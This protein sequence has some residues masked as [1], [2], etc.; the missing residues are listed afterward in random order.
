MKI[1]EQPILVHEDA[2]NDLDY[3]PSGV[4]KPTHEEISVLAHHFY[5]QE[6]CPDA[7]AREHWLAAEERLCG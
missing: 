3:R 7:L 2:D 6:G 1:E 5:E 4:A